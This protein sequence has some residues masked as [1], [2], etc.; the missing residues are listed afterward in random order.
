MD[1]KKRIL[2]TLSLIAL[3]LILESCRHRSGNLNHRINHGINLFLLSALQM[4]NLIFGIVGLVMNGVAIGGKSKTQRQIGGWFTAI[5]G[6]LSLITFA[7]LANEGPEGP[8][9]MIL[10]GFSFIILVVSILLWTRA[11]KDLPNA[12]QK[13]QKTS[14]QKIEDTVSEEEE[15]Y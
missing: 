11:G 3:L 6:L 15:I 12:P 10:Y 13:V 5:F 2:Y 1:R 9:F 8:L 4:F 14:N 7:Y